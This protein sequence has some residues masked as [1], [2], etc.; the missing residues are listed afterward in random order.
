MLEEPLRAGK[1]TSAL[2]IATNAIW[3]YRYDDQDLGRSWTQSEWKDDSAWPEGPAV[4]GFGESYITT[5][6]HDASAPVPMTAYFRKVFRVEDPTATPALW[7]RLLVDDGAVV[8][9]NGSEIF[10]H[11]IPDG[12][13]HHTSR[14]SASIEATNY[15]D[16]VVEPGTLL[17]Q[18]N[19]LAV[20][21]HQCYAGSSDLVFGLELLSGVPRPEE[22]L[23]QPGAPSPSDYWRA[24][25]YLMKA[26]SPKGGPAP[27]AQPVPMSYDQFVRWEASRLNRQ[28]RC[29][30]PW[31]AEWRL[32]DDG[33]DQ[34]TAWKERAWDDRLWKKGPAPL[35]Y[36]AGGIP[37][38][39]YPS[40]LVAGSCYLEFDAN[41]QCL[42]MVNNDGLH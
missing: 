5:Q 8:Y 17:K 23:H 14:A 34:G 42:T 36:S 31:Q 13:M 9:L 35:G 19:I 7:L 32:L 2:L 39:Y 1:L 30:I 6:L 4:L 20:E 41:G 24:A 38:G 37:L 11:N 26:L 40:N 28:A 29:S 3:K 33:S 25:L 22:L 15:L 27:F 21:V 10:R 12:P 18:T 16:F